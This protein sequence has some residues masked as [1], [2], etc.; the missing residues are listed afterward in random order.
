MALPIS[1]NVRSLYVR[2]RVTL[3]AIGGI[4]LVVAVLIVLVAM[5]SGFRIALQ[6]S[7]SS[8]NAIITQRGSTSEITSGIPRDAVNALTV[9]ARVARDKDGNPL[10]S[11]DLAIVASMKRK[12]D[13]VDVNIVVRG[14]REVA[15][16]LPANGGIGV[17]Q[18]VGDGHARPLLGMSGAEGG[19]RT[20][21]RRF[22][23]PL[24]YH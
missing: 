19:I 2:G 20:H 16:Q 22:T 12:A 13:G 4:A 5:A 15:Q 6:A 18:P 10:A 17:E 9:D 11:P 23:K 1:Y 24:L 3:L 8:D 7:G 14:V 21:D